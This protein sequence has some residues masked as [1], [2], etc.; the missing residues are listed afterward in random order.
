MHKRRT[1]TLKSEFSKKKSENCVVESCYLAII[2]L[3]N[4]RQSNF[5]K[6]KYLYNRYLR[7]HYLLFFSFFCSWTTLITLMCV[8]FFFGIFV[9]IK[10][11]KKILLNIKKIR[12][13]KTKGVIYYRDMK[14]LGQ[15]VTLLSGERPTF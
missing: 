1:V 4:K 2:Y 7:N 5:F 3:H 9:F 12:K 15:A 11:G 8:L 6:I 10:N 14:I 13:Q